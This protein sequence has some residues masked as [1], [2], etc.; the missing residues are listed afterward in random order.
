MLWCAVGVA[1]AALARAKKRG[2][3]YDFL[4]RI[5][6]LRSCGAS[7]VREKRGEHVRLDMK[8]APIASA[9]SP[10]DPCRPCAPRG[11]WG[12]RRSRPPS[13]IENLENRLLEEIMEIMEIMER[14]LLWRTT[15]PW[16]F[17]ASGRRRPSGDRGARREQRI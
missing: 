16:S 14:R 2:Q 7:G 3:Q 9:A 10:G 4:S 6:R 13:P 8:K 12:P 1:V 17:A 5:H 15:L 11:I